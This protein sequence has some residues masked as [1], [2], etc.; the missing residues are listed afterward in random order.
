MIF[1]YFRNGFIEPVNKKYLSVTFNLKL[2][3]KKRVVVYG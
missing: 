2:A 3:Q 1:F